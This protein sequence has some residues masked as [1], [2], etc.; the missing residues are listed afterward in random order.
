MRYGKGARRVHCMIAGKTSSGTR[1][2][3]LASAR[4]DSIISRLSFE[5]QESGDGSLGVINCRIKTNRRALEKVAHKVEIATK[6]AKIQTESSGSAESR[7]ATGSKPSS[8]DLPAN[9]TA[10]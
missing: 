3:T 8:I 5:S 2:K 9:S 10:K 6:L 4:M 1:Y 7:L